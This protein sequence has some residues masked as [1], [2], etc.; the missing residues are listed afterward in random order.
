VPP[1]QVATYVHERLLSVISILPLFF[2]RD[3]LV[4]V[5]FH[6]SEGL[7]DTSQNFISFVQCLLHP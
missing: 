2:E 3:D 5:N 7:F 6:S 1:L 4:A